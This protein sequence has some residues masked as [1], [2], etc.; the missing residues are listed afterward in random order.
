MATLT[1]DSP[2]NR[3]ALSARL[4]AELAAGLDRALADDA[5][6]VMVLSHA[7]P[8]FCAGMDLTAHQATGAGPPPVEAFPQV[9]ERIWNSP[10][11]V[12][13]RVAG[14]A[15]AGG[16]GL[17]AACDVALAGE[18]ADFAFTEVR[19][20]V[21]PA[22]I[23]LPVLSRMLPRAA[24]ELFLTG[25][26]FGAARA[27]AVGLVNRAV[28]DDA[29]DAEVDRYCGMLMAGAPGAL[30]G[31]KQLLRRTPGPSTAE[32]LAALA[33]LSARYFADAEGQEGIAAFRERRPASWVP[34]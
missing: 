24:H 10:K 25:E 5:V 15:R 22:V 28:P 33:A 30:A 34:R 20:G 12:V 11:P 1:L 6:R 3:N 7:G 26:T 19:V 9:L 8:V 18:S 14:K 16:L 2:A 17:V 27:A 31:T 21:I 13:A 29:L 23:S 4:L 32:D